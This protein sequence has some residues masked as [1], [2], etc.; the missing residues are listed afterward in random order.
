M[1]RLFGK[2]SLLGSL[3]RLPGHL[4][5]PFVMHR[6]RLALFSALSPTVP[7]PQSPTRR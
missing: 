7:A 1:H 4:G 6:Q 3:V 5:R 2:I